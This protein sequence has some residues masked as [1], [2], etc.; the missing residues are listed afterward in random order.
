M[1]WSIKLE[2]LEKIM[3]NCLMKRNGWR[4]NWKFWLKNLI[5]REILNKKS[6]EKIIINVIQFI[7][8]TKVYIVK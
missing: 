2:K 4:K 5:F 3:F 1:L 7:K 6:I 8:T